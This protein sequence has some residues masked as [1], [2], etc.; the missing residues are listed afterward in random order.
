MSVSTG[1]GSAVGEVSGDVVPGVVGA[2]VVVFGV[3]VFGVVVVVGASVVLVGSVGVVGE[4]VSLV[5]GACEVVDSDSTASG[6]V[7]TIASACILLR[8]FAPFGAG[9]L[10]SQVETFSQAWFGLLVLELPSHAVRP[11]TQSLKD[12][13]APVVYPDEVIGPFMV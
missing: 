8:G 7:A 12:M 6:S 4:A 10:G 11:L 1:F 13:P 5:D 9:V 3:V 2:E